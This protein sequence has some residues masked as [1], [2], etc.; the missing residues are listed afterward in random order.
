MN[1]RENVNMQAVRS[2]F[3]F[4]SDLNQSRLQNAALVLSTQ[5]NKTQ[6]CVTSHQ[7]SAQNAPVRSRCDT[8]ITQVP[9]EASGYP[10][11]ARTQLRCFVTSG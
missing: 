3:S 2:R 11:T 4:S 10:V 1:Q 7:D 8:S 9:Q 6:S 5:A